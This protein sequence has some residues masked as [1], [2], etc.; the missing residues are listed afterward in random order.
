MAYRYKNYIKLISLI[1]FIVIVILVILLTKQT[2]GFRD[3]GKCEN[4][5]SSG[6]FSDANCE[7]IRSEDYCKSRAVR[8]RW[9][10]TPQTEQ[11]QNNNTPPAQPDSKPVG[12]LPKENLGVD[13]ER[14][15]DKNI[16]AC[17]HAAHSTFCYW[18]EPGDGPRI[19]EAWE[20][21]VIAAEWEITSNDS[22]TTSGG[23][24]PHAID[25]FMETFTV[26]DKQ[27]GE[28]DKNR[29]PS[30]K[31]KIPYWE[32]SFNVELYNMEGS[33]V[34]LPPKDG[35][36]MP[37]GDKTPLDFVPSKS[38]I[39]GLISCDGIWMAGGRFGV[40][41]KLVQAQV[42]PP[43]LRLALLAKPQSQVSQSH[44]EPNPQPHR[45]VQPVR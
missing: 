24:Y 25:G 34:F 40:T 10:K 14:C 26:K 16:H 15:I 30:L 18:R 36:E 17:N 37:Q 19:T 44:L 21:E 20:A 3:H 22:T 11:V 45:L 23:R 41:W 8:C 4:K 31:L 5:F 43:V 39:K 27:T 33:P 2:E 42:R 35:Q 28:P 13:E 32:G 29:D 9:R 7:R 6:V 38:Y 12:C 1:I